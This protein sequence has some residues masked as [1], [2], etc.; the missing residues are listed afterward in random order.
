MLT[1][2]SCLWWLLLSVRGRGGCWSPQSVHVT[3]VRPAETVVCSLPPWGVVFGLDGS[4][5]QCFLWV[6]SRFSLRFLP[7]C[8]HLACTWVFPSPLD[9]ATLLLNRVHPGC[10]P[11]TFSCLSSAVPEREYGEGKI[12]SNLQELNGAIPGLCKRLAWMIVFTS[13]IEV[14]YVMP[15]NL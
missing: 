6:N 4:T 5:L 10:R 1:G 12:Y 8:A 2:R 11:H 14:Q 7:L 13:C 15:C 9:A 3:P